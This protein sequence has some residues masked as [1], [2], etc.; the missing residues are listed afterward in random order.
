M[1]LERAYLYLE[2]MKVMLSHNNPAALQLDHE[3][4]RRQYVEAIGAVLPLLESNGVM[5]DR[6]AHLE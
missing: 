5:V 2:H 1:N 6:S 3:P 4:Q